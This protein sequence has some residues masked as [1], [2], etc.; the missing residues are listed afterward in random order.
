MEPHAQPA[1]HS[2][3]G[4]ESLFVW[5][6]VVSRAWPFAANHVQFLD[7]A[8]LL[9]TVYYLL[10]TTYYLLLTIYYLLLTTYY[11]LLTTSTYD[12]YY[13]FYGRKALLRIIPKAY[14]NY[15][16]NHAFVSARDPVTA[17]EKVA[18]GRS[19]ARLSSFSSCEQRFP[20]WSSHVYRTF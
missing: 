14:P 16:S 7:G 5:G 19:S 13:F 12:Y 10:R 18:N 20:H 17:R 4:F 3:C 15:T 2:N 9:L 1:A 6:P 8:Y 11:L